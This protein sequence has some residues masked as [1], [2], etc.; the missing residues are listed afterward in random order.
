MATKRYVNMA[1]WSGIPGQGIQILTSLISCTFCQKI[2]AN[3]IFF[4]LQRP[5]ST[6]LATNRMNSNPISQYWYQDFY[7]TGITP[8]DITEYQYWQTS[9]W[10]RATAMK[11]RFLFDCV[12]HIHRWSLTRKAI[13]L[14]FPPFLLFRFI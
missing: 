6:R 3:K 10:T 14:S 13:S 1:Y 8:C 7:Q 11:P 5:I 2:L 4:K 12:Y 9:I